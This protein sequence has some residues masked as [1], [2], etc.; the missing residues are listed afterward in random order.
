MVKLGSTPTSQLG[1]SPGSIAES[2]ARHL[3]AE[4][5]QEALK[6]PSGDITR[7]M[8]QM[9]PQISRS[10][11]LEERRTSTASEMRVPGG[12]RRDFQKRKYGYK[13]STAGKFTS[14]FLEFLTIYGHFAGE[15]LQD[16]DYFVCDLDY[17]GKTFDEESPLLMEDESSSANK[18]SSMKAFFL[19][20]KAFIGTGVLFL[21]KAFYNGGLLFASGM[22]LLFALLSFYCYYL[23]AKTTLLTGVTSFVQLGDTLYGKSMKYIIL[24][25]IIISQYGFV[26]A[27]VI[28]TAENVKA[29]VFNVSTIHLPM[30]LVVSLEA[31]CIIPMSLIRNL[32]KLSLA[33]LLANIFIL[34]GIITIVTYTSIDLLHTGVQEVQ[35]FNSNSWSLFIGVAIFAFEG[36]GLIV[37]IQQSMRHPE[38]FPRVLAGVILVCTCLFIGVGSLGYLTYGDKIN[39]VI[40]MNL[41][42]DSYPVM[43][44]QLVYAMAI[45]LSIPLQLLPAI[46]LTEDKFFKNR[47]PGS[48]SSTTKWIKNI[49]R[50]LITIGL[51]C[52]AYLGS[53]NLDLF[54]SFV[55][56]VACI[57]LVYM[58]PPM[59]HAMA[60]KD[61]QS[62]EWLRKIDWALVIFGGFATVY[63]TYQL[64]VG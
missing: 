13:I 7:D 36:I 31:I 53:S 37:P 10:R 29:F 26:A 60:L 33:A 20:L 30:W 14:N 63:T 46:K 4:D 49:S 34:L 3:P 28:F 39:T 17:R 56:C 52:L 38:N 2:V 48:V 50:G 6:L 25:S 15:D 8:Y 40:I 42:Q 19:L 43:L 22:L 61:D 21:P 11:S 62:K 64:I 44:I 23:L 5:A 54:V 18:S 35:M 16:E 55:G 59:L 45:M 58:Y 57:P 24:F 32:T 47:Q 27:Y 12:F 1:S 51:C 41:P 9:P